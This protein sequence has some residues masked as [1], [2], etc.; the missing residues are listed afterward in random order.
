MATKQLSI[1]EQSPSEKYRLQNIKIIN[2][3]P[4]RK[5]SF[6]YSD[7]DCESDVAKNGLIAFPLYN[8]HLA[9]VNIK[10]KVV[11]QSQSPYVNEP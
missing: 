2:Q 1:G 7:C 3:C 9:M 10:Q 6:T 11:L 4:S 8:S 5:G